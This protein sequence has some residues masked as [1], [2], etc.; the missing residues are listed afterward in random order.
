MIYGLQFA[1]G[2]VSASILFM[3]AAELTLI[4]GV[5]GVL[6]L[7]HGALFMLALF[8]AWSFAQ[9][10]LVDGWSFWAALLVVPLLMAMLGAALEVLLFRRLY[11]ADHLVQV[12]PTIALIYIIDDTV[13]YVWGLSPGTVAIPDSFGGPVEILGVFFPAYYG[14]VVAFGLLM[15]A[16]IWAV[17]HGTEWGMLVRAVSRDRAMAAALGVNSGAVFTAAFAA[18]LWLVGVAAVLF[19]PIG[20]A[21]PGSDMDTAVDAFAVVVIGGLGSIWGAALAAVLIGLVK[22]FGILVAPRFAMSF[23]FAL[24]A[25]VL[26]VRPQ[27]LLGEAE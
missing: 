19:V 11:G 1:S 27:G 9:L 12:L 10:A 16:L 6:N 25:L 7:A 8:L 26:V 17:V 22:S 4:F 2:L 13:R 20:G 5:C 15:A 18:A 24:M 21:N 14:F 23:V 3:V